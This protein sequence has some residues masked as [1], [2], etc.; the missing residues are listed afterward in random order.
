M[1]PFIFVLESDE[2]PDFFTYV[3]DGHSL[4]EVKNIRQFDP[5]QKVTVSKHQYSVTESERDTKIDEIT[6]QDCQGTIYGLR[7]K[8]QFSSAWCLLALV[9]STLLYTACGSPKLTNRYATKRF[10]STTNIDSY[11]VIKA[12]TFNVASKPAA[13]PNTVFELKE[14][15]QAAYI[16]AL[17]DKVKEA[18]DLVKILSQPLEEEEEDLKPEFLTKKTSFTKRVVV[19]VRN[20]STFPADRISKI[21]VTLKTSDNAVK[22]TGCDKIVTEYQTVDLGKLTF[23]NNISG[24]INAGLTSGVTTTGKKTG[25]VVNPKTNDTVANEETFSGTS[26]GSL[27][28]KLGFASEFYEEANLKQRYVVLSGSVKENEVSFYE[29]SISGIDLSGSIISDITFEAS[30]GNQTSRITYKFS[31]LL[32]P[33]TAL[34]TQNDKVKITRNITQIPNVNK[35][36]A[37]DLTYDVV[38]RQVLAKDNTTLEADDAV[39]FIRGS[40]T[41]QKETILISRTEL[42]PPEWIIWDTA[43]KSVLQAAFTLRGAVPNTLYFSSYADAENLLLWLKNIADPNAATLTTDQKLKFYLDE[44][45]LSTSNRKDLAIRVL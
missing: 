42:V 11:A 10:Y 3:V 34:P 20:N 30:P 31:D 18:K 19:S 21:F 12:Y 16:K 24:E 5:N 13:A 15:P 37:L 6:D 14:K 17:A 1:K 2:N 23:K 38:Y 22:I 27:G 4:K 28:G 41:L 35:D 25:N 7:T 44:T 40:K 39:N 8:S 32:D 9:T 29:E 26:G 36:I 43:T 33:K 45:L